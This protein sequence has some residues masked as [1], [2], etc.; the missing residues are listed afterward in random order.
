MSEQAEGQKTPDN[1]VSRRRLLKLGALA[2]G[3]AAAEQILPGAKPVSAETPTPTKVPSTTPTAIPS[4]KDVQTRTAK[5]FVDQTVQAGQLKAA[6]EYKKAAEE[7]KKAEATNTAQAK[8]IEEVLG[9]P[10]PAPTVTPTST[11]TATSTWT[12][13]QIEGRRRAGLLP[14][15]PTATKHPAEEA[16]PTPSGGSQVPGGTTWGVIIPAVIAVAGTVVAVI[17]KP[18]EIWKRAKDAF[19]RGASGT[20]EGTTESSTGDT[21]PH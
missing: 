9:T 14:P 10:T 6:E 19:H 8:K 1:K 21:T 17:T 4:V 11:P 16:T 20:A 5:L 13:E 15:E 7:Y 18:W 12:A 3:V 2:V